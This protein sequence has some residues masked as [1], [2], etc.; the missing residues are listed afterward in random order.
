MGESYRYREDKH[1]KNS[2]KWRKYN[3]A[4]YKY[5]NDLDS[6]Y[7]W[8]IPKK[9]RGSW[10]KDVS[11]GFMVFNKGQHSTFKEFDT[12]N[13]SSVN[14]I[15]KTLE[16]ALKYSDKYAIFYSHKQ[17]WLRPNTKYPVSK[18]WMNMMKKVYE[19]K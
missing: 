14:D 2:Y 3:I 9:D 15:K 5:N 17:D 4:K 10:S 1:F 7:Q 18:E 12:H 19:N 8:V 13:K 16:K 11:V 6:S